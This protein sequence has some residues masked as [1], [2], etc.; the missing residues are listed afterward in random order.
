MYSSGMHRERKPSGP[1]FDH[2]EE[3]KPSSPAHRSNQAMKA[4]NSLE[5]KTHNLY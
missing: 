4:S 3:D 5:G 1:S 2:I